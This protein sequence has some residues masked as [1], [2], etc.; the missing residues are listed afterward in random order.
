MPKKA[1]MTK[2]KKNKKFYEIKLS[3][4]KKSAD[5]FIY[6][7]I[8]KYRWDDEDISAMSFKKELDAVGAVEK[9]NLYINSPGGSVFEGITIHNMLKRHEA[10]IIAHI[11][12]LAASIASVIAMAADKII[13]PSNSMMMIHNAWSFV[14]GNAAKMR[15][16]ADNLD[17]ISSSAKESYLSRNLSISEDELQKMLD[18]ETWLSAE[19]CVKYGLADEIVEENKAAA[20]VSDEVMQYYDNVPD[21]LLVVNQLDEEEDEQ[22]KLEEKAERQRLALKTLL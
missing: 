9:I 13:M 18:D 22:R 16:E 1:V 8:T 11:D 19:D 10:E 3:A 6:G 21:S 17:R 20:C 7:V 14:V 5:I 15:K 2:E 12:A 4:D